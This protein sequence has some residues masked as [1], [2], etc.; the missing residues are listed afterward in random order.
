M[1]F[2][3]KRFFNNLPVRECIYVRYKGKESNI[4]KYIKI[5]YALYSFK[6][7]WML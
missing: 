3:V 2:I 7:V 4:Q 6:N 5:S 1:Y